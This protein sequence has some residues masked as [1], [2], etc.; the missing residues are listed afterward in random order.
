MAINVEK[1]HKEIENA[2]I[3]I[4]GCDE[5]GVVWDVDGTTEIQDQPE[6][7]A[8][9]ATHDP[10]DYVKERQ[11]SAEGDIK[12]IPNWATWTEAEALAY[13]DANV[14]DLASAIGVLKVFA[15]MLVALRNE[16]FP[17]IPGL[18]PD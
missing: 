9:I 10:R 2:G 1:L 8:V 18:G 11:D 17:G 6:V 7:A 14:V 4:S 16:T 13:I 12:R 5:K 15:R 3:P